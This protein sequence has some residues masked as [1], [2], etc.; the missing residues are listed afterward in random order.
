LRQLFLGEVVMHVQSV[1]LLVAEA[2][3]EV[4]QV[5]SDPAGNVGEY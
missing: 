1:W 2:I 4:Q 3:G 5:L